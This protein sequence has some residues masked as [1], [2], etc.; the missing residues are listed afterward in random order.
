MAAGYADSMRSIGLP[1]LP[2]SACAQAFRVAGYAGRF[3]RARMD[4]QRFAQVNQ[5][6]SGWSYVSQ[7][8]ML[9]QVGV[10]LTSLGRPGPLR[11]ED[12]FCVHDS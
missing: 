11:F 5:V 8:A 1:P 12:Y 9:P 4:L 10:D 7:L 2:P 3:V 6:K